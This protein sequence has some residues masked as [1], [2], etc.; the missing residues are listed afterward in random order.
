MAAQAFAPN[1]YIFEPQARAY[2]QLVE[3]F[4]GYPKARIF[5]FGLGDRDG[6]FTLGMRGTDACTFL[7]GPV[8]FKDLPGVWEEARMVDINRFLAEQGLDEIDY[9]MMNIEGYEYI[10]LPYMASTGSIES[11][12]YLGI[13]F[14]RDGPYTWL[15]QPAPYYPEIQE[16]LQRTHEKIQGEKWEVW[17]RRPKAR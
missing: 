8:P 4:A 15:G 12:R 1:L 14:H 11:C 5:N 7:R 10:L 17:R 16:I 9:C 6:T 3:K 13:D 2:Q